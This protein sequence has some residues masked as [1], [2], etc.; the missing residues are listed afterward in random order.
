M[1]NKINLTKADMIN[2]V[3]TRVDLTYIGINVFTFREFENIPIP[4][5]DGFNASLGISLYQYKK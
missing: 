1:K 4:V 5:P 3:V 2:V